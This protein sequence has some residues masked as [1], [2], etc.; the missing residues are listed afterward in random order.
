MPGQLLLL[1]TTKPAEAL[2]AAQKNFGPR[3]VG[4][5]PHGALLH[6]T[7]GLRGTLGQIR[8]VLHTNLCQDGVHRMEPRDWTLFA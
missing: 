8:Y 3:Q 5:A 2:N 4:V 7:E 1:Y 6:L